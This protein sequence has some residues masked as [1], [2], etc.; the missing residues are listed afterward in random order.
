MIDRMNE[1]QLRE[2]RES[3]EKQ[4]NKIEWEIEQIDRRIRIKKRIVLTRE[5]IIEAHKRGVWND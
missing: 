4:Q 2:A 3:L 1:R 5:S